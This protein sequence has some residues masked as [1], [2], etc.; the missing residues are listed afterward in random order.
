MAIAAAPPRL[1]PSRWNVVDA[2]LVEV[3]GERVHGDLGDR[4]DVQV[5]LGGPIAVA[6]PR[7]VG[8]QHPE[9]FGQRR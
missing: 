8:Q 6:E 3:L 4:A 5:F 2:E 7:L 9:A 1:L